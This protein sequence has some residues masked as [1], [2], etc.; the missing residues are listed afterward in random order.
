VDADYCEVLE[1][2]APYLIANREKRLGAAV[3]IAG[4]S[5]TLSGGEALV[6][7]VTAPLFPSYLY[8][9]YYFHDGS[10][11]HLT[12]SVQPVEQR[13]DAG[14]TVTLGEDEQWIVSPPFGTEMIVV[15]ASRDPL[16]ASPRRP[17]EPGA[18]YLAELGRVLE[19]MLPGGATPNAAAELIVITTKASQ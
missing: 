5:R 17:Q 3:A 11:V 18:D 2:Y 8:V 14:V 13:V 15:M 12:P 7:E 19:G 10:V 9:D 6:L 4:G 1:V 16:F